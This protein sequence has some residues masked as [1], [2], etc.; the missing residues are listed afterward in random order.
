[1]IDIEK[2]RTLYK[3]SKELSLQDAQDLLKTAK[4]T[5]FKKKEIIFEEGSK[6]T[7]IYFLREGLV[8]MYHIKENGEEITFSLIPENNVVANFDFI[9]TEKPSPFYYETL[10]NCSFFRID[11]QVLDNIVSKNEN[12]EA[13][14]KYFLRKMIFKVKERL[15]TFVLLNPEERYLKF[16]KDFPDL[17]NRVPDKY[18]ANVLGITPVSLSRI[19]KRISSK[20]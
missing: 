5:S 14:R 7:Q 17:T 8:R 4:S 6:D 18:I 2:L 20:K 13:N 3:F 1:M 10:E 15:E 19:R 12:L 16:I 11:Y 9:A